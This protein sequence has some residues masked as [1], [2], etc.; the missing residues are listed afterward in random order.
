[1]GC[2]FICH[3]YD[4]YNYNDKK[5]I[6]K[7]ENGEDKKMGIGVFQISRECFDEVNVKEKKNTDLKTLTRNL[8]VLPSGNPNPKNFTIIETKTIFNKFVPYT[9]VLIQYHNCNNYEGRKI[10]VY[11][12]ATTNE[13]INTKII[14]PH[15]SE[16]NNLGKKLIARFVP[17][18]E[19]MWM[20]ERFIKSLSYTEGEL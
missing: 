17:A 6:T 15:F 20:A 14:D 10:L 18:E 2:G 19:G 9:I 1:M 4:D 12:D 5:T 8:D 3:G 13:I 11:E 7:K 16:N